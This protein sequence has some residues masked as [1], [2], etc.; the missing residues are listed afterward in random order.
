MS[1]CRSKPDDRCDRAGIFFAQI[2]HEVAG[3]WNSSILSCAECRLEKSL[4]SSAWCF[5]F[6]AL[7]HNLLED[8]GA[9][10]HDLVYMMTIIYLDTDLIDLHTCENEFYLRQNDEGCFSC[11]S[12]YTGEPYT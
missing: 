3:S 10:S 2:Q 8:P 7:V 4:S 11:S 6:R 9:L 1:E 5:G 12:R